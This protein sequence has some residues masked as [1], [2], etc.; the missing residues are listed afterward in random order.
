MSNDKKKRKL[1]IILAIVLVLI[2]VI[3]FSILFLDLSKYIWPEKVTEEP[4]DDGY[5]L[6]S[7]GTINI[8][9][10]IYKLKEDNN[11]IV[12]SC[13]NSVTTVE[14]LD[15]LNIKDTGV[16]NEI[17]ENA[18]KDCTQI[19]QI[20]I[21]STITKINDYAFNNCK[22]LTTITIP[23]SVM[24]IG[25]ACFTDCTSLTSIKVQVSSNYFSDQNG[26]LYDI[27]GKILYAY[28]YKKT[29]EAYVLSDMLESIEKNVFRGLEKLRSVALPKNLINLGESAFENCSNLENVYIP[30]SVETIGENAFA[31]CSENLT[32]YGEEGSYAETYA[33]ENGIPFKNLNEWP[34]SVNTEPTQNDNDTEENENSNE[35]INDENNNIEENDTN[36]V[37]EEDIVNNDTENTEDNTTRNIIEI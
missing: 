1:I 29:D 17:G 30:A 36:T 37:N 20:Y 28:P 10:V 25:E 12:E 8:D 27:D 4:E 35:Q 18:F 15:N 16:V 2:N 6:S 13:E 23:Y 14:I 22:S 33:N 32:I 21:P 19:T 26:V 3:V 5:K 9:G 34:V 24:E 31:N 7:D 11:Y